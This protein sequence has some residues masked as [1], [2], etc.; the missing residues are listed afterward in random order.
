MMAH[1]MIVPHYHHS[2]WPVASTNLQGQRKCSRVTL[3]CVLEHLQLNLIPQVI[4]FH[5]RIM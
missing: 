1:G 2:D 3:P 5:S 4:V